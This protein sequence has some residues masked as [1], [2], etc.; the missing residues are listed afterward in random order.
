MVILGN[1]SVAA[2]QPYKRNLSILR[3]IIPMPLVMGVKR[4][5]AIT[6]STVVVLC[7]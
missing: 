1:V 6:Y 2:F 4:F 5:G 3:G 7:S